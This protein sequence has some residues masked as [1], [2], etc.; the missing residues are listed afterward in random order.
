[1]L[2]VATSIATAERPAIARGRT[3]TDSVSKYRL[4]DD[5]SPRQIEDFLINNDDGE[6]LALSLIARVVGVNTAT[7]RVDI[8]HGE[9]R[10]MKVLGSTGRARRRWR[11]KFGE[12]KR[13]LIAMGAID[14]KPR[15]RTP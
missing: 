4:S 14:S 10:A 3:R 11:V 15:R 8:S 13:Y 9:L 2:N 7:I 1:M 6:P 12:A 5:A